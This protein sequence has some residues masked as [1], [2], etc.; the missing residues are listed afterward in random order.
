MSE[1]EGPMKMEWTGPPI[2]DQMSFF[3]GLVCAGKSVREVVAWVGLKFL[4]G[5]KRGQN[6]LFG[7]TVS[8]TWCCLM[9][10]NLEEF[11]VDHVYR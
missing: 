7:L 3:V 6:C 10:W 2:V 11:F 8:D 4:G 5:G 9:G 1:R